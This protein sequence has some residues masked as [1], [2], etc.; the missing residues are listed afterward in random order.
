MCG[1]GFATEAV[2]IEEMSCT[3]MNLGNKLFS[4]IYF[5]P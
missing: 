4:E 3:G 2:D 5:L 1:V